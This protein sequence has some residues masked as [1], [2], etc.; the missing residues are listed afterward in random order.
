MS[1]TPDPTPTPTATAIP[2]LYSSSLEF[3]KTVIVALNQPPPETWEIFDRIVSV[4]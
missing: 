4:M 3:K 1:F 2:T